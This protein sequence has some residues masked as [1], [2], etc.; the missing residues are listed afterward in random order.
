MI[1][2]NVSDFIGDFYIIFNLVNSKTPVAKKLEISG[3]HNIF[4]SKGI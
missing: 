1:R 3:D 4:A 2:N